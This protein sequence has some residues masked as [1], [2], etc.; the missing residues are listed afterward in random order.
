[1]I[2][3]TILAPVATKKRGLSPRSLTCFLFGEPLSSTT[4]KNGRRNLSALTLQELFD[5]AANQCGLRRFGLRRN[6]LQR[7]VHF[8]CNRNQL[9]RHSVLSTDNVTVVMI[10]CQRMPRQALTGDT[11]CSILTSSVITWG[12]IMEMRRCKVCKQFFPA[13]SDYFRHHLCNPGTLAKT[14]R[15]CFAK[16][17]GITDEERDQLELEKKQEKRAKDQAKRKARY[18]SNPEFKEQ[19]LSRSRDWRQQHKE[20]ANEVSRNYQ[21][22]HPEVVK[23]IQHNRRTRI[24]EAVND[25]KVEEWSN[26]LEYFGYRCAVCGEP[27]NFW[28]SI[29]IDHW[30]PV[31][32]GGGSTVTNIIPLCHS[33]R[34]APAGKKGCNNSK[35]DTDPVE[36]LERTYGKRKAKQILK[37]IEAYF[38]WVREQQ[39]QKAA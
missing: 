1:M 18:H 23:I 6:F 30:I 3:D 29:A 9:A 33:K 17:T 27:S 24:M 20:K 32:R 19:C 36:W 37:Q 5:G 21:R 25:L 38:E 16:T 39:Q 7:R 34:G 10:A 35:H 8:F 28:L 12:F 14:C 22:S 4:P 2:H 31:A 13:T 15:T 11:K 26:C